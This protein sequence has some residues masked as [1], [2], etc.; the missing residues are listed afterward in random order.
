MHT[1]TL[2][3]RGWP[4]LEHLTHGESELRIGPR[5]GFFER[6]FCGDA[7]SAFLDYN[8]LRDSSDFRHQLEDFLYI[9]FYGSNDE[10]RDSIMN[11]TLVSRMRYYLSPS[12]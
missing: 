11:T 5:K 9:S 6:L 8:F 10:V 12:D 7:R 2:S 4:F 3:G 1:L